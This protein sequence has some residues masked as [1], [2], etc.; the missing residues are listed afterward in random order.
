MSKAKAVRFIKE[1]CD[2]DIT[3]E[4]FVLLVQQKEPITQATMRSLADAGLRGDGL[5]SETPAQ[6]ETVLA[7]EPDA[8]V[9][10]QSATVQVQVLRV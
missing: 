5:L 1:S 4:E 8:S 3:F 6:E 2:H 9:A 10:A 7:A